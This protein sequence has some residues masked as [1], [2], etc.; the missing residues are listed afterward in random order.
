MEQENKN[1]K[2]KDKTDGIEAEKQALNSYVKYTGVAFQMMAIIGLSAYIGYKTDQYYEHKT[3]W[4]TA[5]ACVLG[6]FLSIYQTIRQ[7]RP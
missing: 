4:V 6:V 1:H 5:I 2:K 7:L 3:Q